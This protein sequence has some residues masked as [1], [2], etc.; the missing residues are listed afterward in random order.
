MSDW[1]EFNPD[2]VL[3]KVSGEVDCTSC[4]AREYVMGY[5]TDDCIDEL[6]ELG[7][8]SVDDCCYCPQCARELETL[9]S[10]KALPDKK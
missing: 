1:N 5:D 4:G 8:K 9:C 7:W 10:I 6:I 2:F 3:F